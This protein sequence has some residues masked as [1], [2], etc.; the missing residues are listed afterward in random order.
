[1]FDTKTGFVHIKAQNVIFFFEKKPG[2]IYTCEREKSQHQFMGN[3]YRVLA[4][5]NSFLQLVATSHIYWQT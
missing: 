5:A 2:Q 1:M 3:S 4:V